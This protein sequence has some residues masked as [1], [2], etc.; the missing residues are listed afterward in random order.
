MQFPVD[1]CRKPCKQ[2]HARHGGQLTAAPDAP[3]S[4]SVLVSL[5]GQHSQPS[6]SACCL[7][8]RTYMATWAPLPVTRVSCGWTAPSELVPFFRPTG[9]PRPR[10]CAC[11]VWANV[12]HPAR[13]AC[14][15]AKPPSEWI[16]STQWCPGSRA[17]GPC[18]GHLARPCHHV[19]V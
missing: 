18:S 6:G 19:H 10:V 13:S 15:L 4:V 14:I 11:V 3:R 12:D 9:M 5:S 2:N 1:L 8:T 16:C 17:K 7:L